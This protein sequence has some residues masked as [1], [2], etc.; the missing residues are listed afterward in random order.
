MRGVILDRAGRR[1]APPELLGPT[2]LPVYVERNIENG[3]Y[4]PR[5]DGEREQIGV[6]FG[7]LPQHILDNL[8]KAGKAD[9]SKASPFLNSGQGWRQVEGVIAADTASTAVSTEQLLV[10]P[11]FLLA[12]PRP[13]PS[14]AYVTYEYTLMGDLSF[15]VTT[16]GTMSLRL[17][18]GGVAGVLL[19]PAPTGILPTGTQVI[20]TNSFELKW[21]VTIRTTPTPTTA[22]AWCQGKLTF[23]GVF[24][25][26]P[27]STTII[28]AA[29]KA[30]LIP[31]SAPAVSAA[32]DVSIAKAL[33]P[34]YQN[35]LTTA[36][37]NT[38]LAY[39]ES[40]N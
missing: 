40:L 35:T 14:M 15:A 34:T 37:F 4:M 30:Q 18:W 38:H 24:E 5:Y 3:W 8:E 28:V 23:P 19:H 9:F 29:L 10:N 17:R 16:P 1:V 36:A 7:R 32:L 6:D 27:A 11:D 26:T 33:S 12:V 31:S 39:V 25:T 21:R 20:T 13:G 22:T 2:G